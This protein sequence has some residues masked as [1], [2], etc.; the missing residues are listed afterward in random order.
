[1][2]GREVDKTGKIRERQRGE[3]NLT[4]P[5]LYRGIE[6]KRGASKGNH[7]IQI[8]VQREIKPDEVEGK[9]KEQGGWETYR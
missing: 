1:M 3:G 2:K 4:F 6:E 5:T 8:Y 7:F 9:I